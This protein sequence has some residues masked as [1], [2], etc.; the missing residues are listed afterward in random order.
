MD[1]IVNEFP[2]QKERINVVKTLLRLVE[3]SAF[4]G[5]LTKQQK[6]KGN[7]LAALSASLSATISD[8]E[9]QMPKY[10]EI[11]RKQVKLT[12]QKFEKQTED[13]NELLKL[14]RFTTDTSDIVKSSRELTSLIE[15]MKNLDEYSKKHRKYE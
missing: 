2:G 5:V 3:E 8:T 10:I 14:Q 1:K 4:S 6:E 11:F 15:K 9:S 12:L 7:E 13:I